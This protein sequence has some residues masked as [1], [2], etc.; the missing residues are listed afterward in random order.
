[1]SNILLG[2]SGVIATGRIKR[3]SQ[4]RNHFAHKG[5][6][7]QSYGFFSSHVWTWELNHKEGWLLKNW[8]FGTVV[9]RK[10]GESPLD[11]KEIKP[12]H[13]KG[14]QPLKF[15]RRTDAEAEAP[16]LRQSDVKCWLIGKDPDA[17]KDWRQEEKGTIENEMAGW[18][19]WLN[20]YVL[21]QALGDGG[22]QGSLASCSPWGFKEPDTTEQLNSNNKIYSRYFSW[23]FVCYY[24]FYAGSFIFVNHIHVYQY[25]C[26]YCFCLFKVLYFY[27]MKEFNLIYFQCSYVF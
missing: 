25:I 20:G 14:N 24:L 9:L 16:I 12:I 11:C 18:H 4:S 13:P 21:E 27:I 22:G 8:R 1:M 23:I 6:S 15:I 26:S 7:S 2:K 19:H 17:G 5:L 3:L 10:T